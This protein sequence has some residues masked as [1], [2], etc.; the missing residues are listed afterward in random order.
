MGEPFG[1]VARFSVVDAC[2]ESKNTL[3]KVQI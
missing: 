2:F 3:E 1:E